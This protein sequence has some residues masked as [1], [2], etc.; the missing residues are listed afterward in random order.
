MYCRNCGK[1][2]DDKAV[3]CV[4]CGVPPLKGTKYC[5]GCGKE[6]D[7]AAE[8]C[9]SCGVQL[10]R[11]ITVGAG[12]E[13]TWG[14]L[15]HLSMI[16]TWF[17]GPL[18]VLL[19]KGNESEFVKDQAKEALNFIITVSICMI[20]L[21]IVGSVLTAVFWVFGLL[22]SLVYMAVGVGALVLTIMAGI[23]ANSGNKYRYPWAIRLIK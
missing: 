14:M 13:K 7:E 9:V 8:V 21:V 12:D 5:Q 3:V 4:G 2:V 11:G 6:V 23:Q 22:F 1:E 20:G 10:S 17:I 19:V 15:A 16:V 18:V